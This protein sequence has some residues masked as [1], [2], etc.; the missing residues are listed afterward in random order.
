MEVATCRHNV[1]QM[2]LNMKQGEVYAYPLY[3]IKN[4]ML[5]ENVEF[6][7]ADVNG[8]FKKTTAMDF[9]VLFYLLNVKGCLLMVL[10]AKKYGILNIIF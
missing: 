7:F 9:I 5:P 10:V 1:G 4:F 3:L 2:A 6:V 8:Q